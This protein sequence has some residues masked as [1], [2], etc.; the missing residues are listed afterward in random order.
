MK[1]LLSVLYNRKLLYP[2]PLIII[3]L[4]SGYTS[5]KIISHK[6]DMMESKLLNHQKILIHKYTHEILSTRSGLHTNHLE[7][8]KLL[9]ASINDLLAKHNIDPHSN[10]SSNRS[11][12]I[13]PKI[14]RLIEHKNLFTKLVSNANILLNSSNTVNQTKL[15]T[16]TAYQFIQSVDQIIHH[17]TTHS[18]IDNILYI[19]IVISLGII[20]LGILISV[21]D[22]R[23]NIHLSKE[24]SSRI[25]I[26]N[27]LKQNH[28]YLNNIL[29]DKTVELNN[30]MDQLQY[31]YNLRKYAI[32]QSSEAIIIADKQGIIQYVNPALESLTGYSKQELLGSKPGI[33]K[34][35]LHNKQFYENLWCQLEVD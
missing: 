6:Q 8:E 3:I 25:E 9:L 21:R 11:T 19:N 33:L 32:E 23:S 15:F 13:D 16:D 22:H 10:T 28:E 30:T 27:T 31:E 29:N 7:T 12:S 24:I 5:L 1:K 20:F 18:D 35:G 17:H 26:E 34:S 4:S 14:N 2:I